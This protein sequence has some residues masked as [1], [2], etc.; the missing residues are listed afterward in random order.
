M[1]TPVDAYE[2]PC[3]QNGIPIWHCKAKDQQGNECGQRCEVAISK[4]EKNDGKMYHKCNAKDPVTQEYH[5][6]RKWVND[7]EEKQ[8]GNKSGA[9]RAPPS[10]G[11]SAQT[12]HTQS[13]QVASSALMDLMQKVELLTGAVLEN[14]DDIKVLVQHI[15]ASMNQPKSGVAVAQSSLPVSSNPYPFPGGSGYANA[16]MAGAHSPSAPTPS[17]SPFSP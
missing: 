7:R 16:G 6:F 2:G 8:R 10:S 3:D 9:T 13:A 17:N 15:R 1:S 14:K 5:N 12:V 4:S 11:Q